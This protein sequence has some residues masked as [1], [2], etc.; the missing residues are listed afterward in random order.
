MFD[1]KLL[2]VPTFDGGLV[3]AW[4]ISAALFS[5]LT[6][7]VLYLQNILGYSAVQAGVRFLPLTVAIFLTAGVAGRLSAKVP[8]RLLIAP[9]FAL[10]GAGLL[11]MRGL[12]PSSDWTHLLPGMIVAGVGAGLVNVP[13]AST[14]VGVVAPARAGMASGINTTFRQVGIAT[15]VAALGAIL[16]AQLRDSVVGGLAGTPLAGQAHAIA[17]R[18]SSGDIAQAVASAPPAVRSTV[19]H[20]AQAGFVDGLNAILLVGAIVAFAATVLTASLIRS[21][22]FVDAET[23]SE[24]EAPA[25]AAAPA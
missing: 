15:G 21:R 17:D 16:A 20:T 4:A 8:V 1:F 2:R 12:D 7:L 18:V 3:A 9:G 6:Y 22:D 23:Q 14:A 13:L 10:I 24:G 25:V 11:L 5:L 19:A